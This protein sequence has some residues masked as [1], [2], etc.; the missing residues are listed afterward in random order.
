MSVPPSTPADVSFMLGQ[1]MAMCQS[2]NV[3]LDRIETHVGSVDGR[4]T[5]LERESSIRAPLIPL[6]HDLV[7]R[8][9]ELERAKTSS[10]TEEKTR[11]QML[12]I[13][14]GIGGVLVTI[15]LSVGDWIVSAIF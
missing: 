10:A 1:I 8:V 2:T 3:K 15:A 6:L 13:V 11:R 5:V 14:S 12:M 7:A 4:V 9:I